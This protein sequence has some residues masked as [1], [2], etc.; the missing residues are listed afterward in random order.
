MQIRQ[1][2]RKTSRI[3]TVIRSKL[4]TRKRQ[5]RRDEGE[6]EIT[7]RTKTKAFSLCLGLTLLVRGSIKYVFIV[8]LMNH[9]LSIESL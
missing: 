6:L 8:P 9:N 7:D 1:E 5:A 4:S 3:T 2:N